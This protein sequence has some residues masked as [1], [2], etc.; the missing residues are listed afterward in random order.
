MTSLLNNRSYGY[1]LSL[2]AGEVTMLELAKAYM[3][4]SAQ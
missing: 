4:L 2:G 1:S 3:H